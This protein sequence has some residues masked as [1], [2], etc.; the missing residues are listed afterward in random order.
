MASDSA[1]A[2]NTD[3]APNL[4]SPGRLRGQAVQVDPSSVTPCAGGR[5]YRATLKGPNAFPHLRGG[6]FGV[7]AVKV[8]EV[9]RTRQ[10]RDPKKEARILAGLDHPNIL[11]VLNAYLVEGTPTSP[12]SRLSL[13]TPYYPFTLRDLLDSPA[14]TPEESVP[15]FTL[16][17]KSIAYQLSSAVA[18]LHAEQE[19][20]HRDINPNNVVLSQA[21]RVVLIDFGISVRSGDEQAGEMHFEVG[22]GA[23]RAPE[24]I[25]GSRTYDPFALDLWALGCTLS[26]LFRPLSLPSPPSPPSSEDSFERAYRQ[27]ATPEPEPKLRR[28]TLFDASLSDFVLAASIFRVLGTPTVEAWPEAAHL[29]NFSRFTFA[30]FPPTQLA[31]HLPYLAPTS[32]LAPILPRLLKISASE[33]VPAT[34]VVQELVGN[35]KE[36]VLLPDDIDEEERKRLAP[37][38]ASDVDDTGP[39][40][41]RL[42]R[43]LETMLLP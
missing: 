2:Y 7:V 18:Y 41:G 16:L 5:I 26:D 13:F 40:T 11:S 30:P 28:E 43:A 33:R 32:S 8:T 14:F 36:G 20:A 17:T 37:S 3:H 1:P 34:E 38:A 22:T 39:S 29:P 4:F 19:I 31:S 24:L 6:Q 21:G 27:H 10:P 25:F 35:L 23:Y 9:D 42:R 12:T 15:D